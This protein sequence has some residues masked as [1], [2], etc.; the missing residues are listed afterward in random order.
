[1]RN[2]NGE[3]PAQRLAR[4]LKESG[5]RA[6]CVAFQLCHNRDEARELVQE[7]C[8]Q[9]LQHW[10]QYDPTRSFKSWFLAILKHEFIDR[11]RG[12]ER[13]NRSLDGH[14]ET[15]EGSMPYLGLLAG[16][17]KPILETLVHE[18]ML[19]LAR[20][21]YL[22]LNPPH[23]KVI[24]LCDIAGLQ[25]DDAARRLGV[26]TGTIRSRVS[27]AREKLRTAFHLRELRGGN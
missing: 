23:R 20:E 1:M 7:A 6:Y 18:E 25:Y 15:E 13:R 9:A 2:A 10:D 4:F 22:T 3:T 21:A 16:T 5:E 26:P 12:P 24:A 27:R 8:Y 17:D 19:G 14:V 11:R